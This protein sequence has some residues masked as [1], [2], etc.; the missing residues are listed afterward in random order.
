MCSQWQYKIPRTTPIQLI[1]RLISIWHCVVSFGNTR[2]RLCTWLSYL[3]D[4]RFPKF[5]HLFPP[6]VWFLFFCEIKPNMSTGRKTLFLGHLV[7]SRA[8]V[9]VLEIRI[10][11]LHRVLPMEW[12]IGESVTAWARVCGAYLSLSGDWC[13]HDFP[14]VY[15][16]L[17]RPYIL[18]PRTDVTRWNSQGCNLG[19][20][21]KTRDRGAF[22]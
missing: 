3:K 17:S 1:F 10:V 5:E 22:F 2:Q 8:S 9:E 20:M 15:C 19:L 7:R 14:C 12:M 11:R 16:L 13:R 18:I 4:Y 21:C 6:A